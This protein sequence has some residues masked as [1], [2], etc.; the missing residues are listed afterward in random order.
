[1][2][3]EPSRSETSQIFRLLIH[4]RSAAACR[5][6]SRAHE[7]ARGFFADANRRR[8]HDVE[9]ARVVR[10]KITRAFD[11][12]HHSNLV[13]FVQRLRAHAIA[14]NVLLHLAD[15]PANR[16]GDLLVRGA[17]REANINGVAHHDW[18]IGGIEHDDR[19]ATA[20]ATEA[21]QSARGRLRELVDVLSG[22]GASARR[23]DRRD[24]FGILDRQ[25]RG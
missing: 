23:R 6:R 25:R 18:R 19:F 10:Q 22:A 2:T 20:R 9:V 4:T 5:S 24:D 14:G 16:C 21:L 17:R 8:R 11:F 15:H 7:I 13:V 3:C 12:E 1:M